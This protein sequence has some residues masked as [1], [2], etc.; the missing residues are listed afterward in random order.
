MF[1]CS[2]AG[3]LWTAAETRVYFSECFADF[4]RHLQPVE[5]AENPKTEGL[6]DGAR[7][8]VVCS[9]NHSRQT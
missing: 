7:G 6:R 2:V 3:F 4:G 1:K 9:L 8:F 5:E